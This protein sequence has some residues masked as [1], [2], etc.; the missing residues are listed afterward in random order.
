MKSIFLTIFALFVLAPVLT[1]AQTLSSLFSFE[2]KTADDGGIIY[3]L[4][5]NAGDIIK[6]RGLNSPYQMIGAVA[7][8]DTGKAVIIFANAQKQFQLAVQRNKSVSIIADGEIIEDLK[9]E[10]AAQ[11]EG[12]TVIK[13]EIGNTVMSYRE[14]EKMMNADSVTVTYGAVSYQLDKENLAALHYFAAQIEKDNKKQINSG[15]PR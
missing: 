10:M 6:K 5:P 15:A 4:T 8:P 3:T 7:R 2:R 1:P 13:L 11:S 12:D 14:F 9:Y